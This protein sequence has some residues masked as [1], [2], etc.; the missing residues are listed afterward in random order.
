MEEVVGFS[1]W[2]YWEEGWLPKLD[3]DNPKWAT[4]LSAAGWMLGIVEDG[5]VYDDFPR[6]VLSSQ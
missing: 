6:E 2:S 4:R 5:G 3:E 1:M